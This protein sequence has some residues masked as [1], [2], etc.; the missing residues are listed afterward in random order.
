MQKQLLVNVEKTEILLLLHLSVLSLHQ[1]NWVP[2]TLLFIE[3]DTCSPNYLFLLYVQTSEE[4][5]IP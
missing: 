4:L 2:F 5:N 3:G 1:F